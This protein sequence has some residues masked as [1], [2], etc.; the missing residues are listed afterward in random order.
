MPSRGGQ[1]KSLGGYFHEVACFNSCP[2]AE[3]NSSSKGSLKTWKKF[4]FVPSRGGQLPRFWSLSIGFQVSIRALTRRATC[5]D[6]QLSGN[7]KVSIRA[8]TR[9]ATCFTGHVL[10]SQEFQFVPS[11]GGQLVPLY[12]VALPE[13]FQFVPSRG[14]QLTA[15]HKPVELITFQ[16]VPS[17]GGQHFSRIPAPRSA[18]CFNSCPHA[19]GNVKN[20][21]TEFADDS[22]NSCP[23]AEGNAKSCFLDISAFCFNSCPHAEGNARVG[24]YGRR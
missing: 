17:R 23:H 18:R 8:L 10:T 1:L 24:Q 20:V 6:M 11:R 4:Q 22:F 9:R 15:C 16:F 2:H 14:G 7:R 12:P 5:A 19:E 13:V 21:T 3:G